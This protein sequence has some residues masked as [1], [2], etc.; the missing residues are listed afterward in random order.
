MLRQVTLNVSP[1]MSI[2]SHNSV[3]KVALTR[4]D[5]SLVQRLLLIFYFIVETSKQ[6]LITETYFNQSGRVVS[7]IGS[8]I[9]YKQSR[10]L[11]SRHLHRSRHLCKYNS[12]KFH[13]CKDF[14]I[15]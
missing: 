3:L 2:D 5:N 12:L 10:L 1:M 7:Y 14:Q 4:Y 6:Y 13:L 9:I 8:L 15:H 11:M